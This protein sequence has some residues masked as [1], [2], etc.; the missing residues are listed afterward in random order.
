M[1]KLLIT[2][3]F[4]ELTDIVGKTSQ[5]DFS[6]RW[7]HQSPSYLRTI[8]SQKRQPTIAVWEDLLASLLRYEQVI[9]TKNT[10]PMLNQKAQQIRLIAEQIAS[11][12]AH[13]QIASSQRRNEARMLMMEAVK[14]A[15]KSY[16][17]TYTEDAPPI[18]IGF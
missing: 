18:S 2:D 10:H 8:K 4:T 12:I 16:E 17:G 6:T 13:Q 7:L 14:K 3:I 11:H 15:V 9:K 5:E 1:T